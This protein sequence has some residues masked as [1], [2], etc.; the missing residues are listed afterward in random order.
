MLMN[1]GDQPVHSKNKL[2]TTIAYQIN[3][4]T[5]Y[6][7]EG[8]VFIG[9]AVVQWLRDSLGVIK[10]SAEV[11]TLAASVTDN[12]GV[13]FV[14]AFTGLGAPYWYPYARGAILGLTRGSTIGHIARAAIEGIAYQVTDVLKAM[15]SD[16]GIKIE[17]MRVDGGAAVD[18]L[19]MQ[20]Q[21]DVL[22]VD[23]VRPQLTEST[24]IG[25]AFLAGLAVQFWKNER[26]IAACWKPEREFKPQMAPEKA[27]VLRTRWKKAIDCAQLWE[28]RA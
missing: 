6:A 9:G 10:T 13:Y 19:L 25:A 28:E 18:D 2:L 17:Q 4:K 7:L 3:G 8:S 11:Q 21:S 24:A 23:T 16:A 26:E 15:E 12:N 1:T 14:P 5:T 22:G 27:Q 20:F